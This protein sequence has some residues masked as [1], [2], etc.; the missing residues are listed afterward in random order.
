MKTMFDGLFNFEHESD[1]D[2]FV[3]NMDKRSSVKIIEI[4][5]EYGQIKGLYS[6]QESHCLYKCLTKLKEDENKDGD[7]R[8]NDT[9]GNSNQ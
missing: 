5:I 9:D 8:D 7:I 1:L 3:E 4:A 6:L 2:F